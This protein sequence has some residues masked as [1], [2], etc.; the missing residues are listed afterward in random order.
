MTNSNLLDRVRS[1]NEKLPVIERIARVIEAR[2]KNTEGIVGVVRPT[3]TGNF[4]P[5]DNQILLKQG[6]DQRRPELDCPGNPPAIANEMPFSVMLELRPSDKDDTSIDT[7]KNTFRARAITALTKPERE[8]DDWVTFNRLAVNSRIGNATPYL[9]DAG[10]VAG[11]KLTIAV[12][13]RHDENNPC[14]LRA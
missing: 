11:I 10:E 9:D 4:R 12:I 13:Y 14:N 2:L 3:R 1:Q 5:K 8:G 6:D 7:F